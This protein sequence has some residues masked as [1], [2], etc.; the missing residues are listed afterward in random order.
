M[1]KYTIEDDFG[2]KHTTWSRKEA[3]AWLRA[4]SPKASIRQ[5]FLGLFFPSVAYRHQ[6]QAVKHDLK[7]TPSSKLMQVTFAHRLYRNLPKALPKPETPATRK[8]P[9][10]SRRPLQGLTALSCS[11]VHAK[12]SQP[13]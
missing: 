11:L 2:S 4:A 3:F 6:P 9:S 5:A 13:A 1:F 8:V 10:V 7:I 12:S